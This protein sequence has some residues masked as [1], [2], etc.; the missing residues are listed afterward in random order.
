MSTRQNELIEK[1]NKQVFL[2]MKKVASRASP[3]DTGD[4]SELL[5]Y[6]N[7]NQRM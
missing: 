5:I 7:G 3:T 2:K 6:C 1:E 4:R